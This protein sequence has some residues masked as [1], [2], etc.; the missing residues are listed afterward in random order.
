MSDRM[1]QNP[2]QYDILIVDDTPDSL[3]F[4]SRILE[5]SGFR[6]RAATNGRHA[7]KSVEAR[8]PGLILL[9]VRMPEMDGYEVCRRLKASKHSRNVP[10]IFISA[11][12]ETAEKLRGFKAGAVDFITKP[13]EEQEVL[14]RVQ[15]HLRLRE[16][17][18][19]LE[20]K[21]NQRTADLTLANRQL[22]KHRDHLEDLVKART[23]ELEVANKELA[24]AKEQAEAANAHK[25]DFL[26]RMSHDIRTP[27]NAVTGLTN[28]VLKSNLNAEQRDCLNKVK[29]AA[30]NLMQL[31]NDILD[32]TKVE[33]GRLELTHAPF[34]LDQVMDR[35]ADLFSD[36]VSKKDLKLRFSVAP[37]VPRLL[38]G[39]AARLSQVLS[40]LIGNAIKFTETGEIV[41]R[42]EPDNADLEENAR[43]T[44]KFSVSDT[45]AGIAADVLPTLFDPFTQ[46]DDS[47]T[48]RHEGTGLGLAICRQLAELLGGRIWAESTP[49]NGST[50]SFTAMLETRMEQPENA[51]P[52]RPQESAAVPIPHLAGRR[53]LVVEDIELNR[54]VAVMLLEE[55]GLN[56]EIAENGKVAVNKVTSS[57]PEYYDAVLMDIQMPVMDGYE[58]TRY[59]REWEAS[60]CAVRKARRGIAARNQHPVSGIRKP[61]SRIPIIAL[62]AHALKGEEEKCLAADMDDYLPKPIDEKNLH[63]VLLKWLS[64][65]MNETDT[66]RQ[67]LTGN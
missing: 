48:R 4:L 13:Y 36:Q 30:G 22:K 49:G 35:Q 57:G 1:I 62:T 45:G 33:A 2:D 47:L 16:L 66:K 58:A 26:A 8:L 5:V 60:E 12:G 67:G 18:E 40:N 37:K 7:L 44:L 9:D 56:V 14:A 46:A 51:A 50:F 31:I 24:A 63:R 34:D 19:H 20:H 6:V 41:V 21:V 61:G 59:I 42:V 17:T 53:V 23:G 27:L 55:I 39:D 28:L 54:D 43:V 38:A 65:R 32:F 29:L 11:L 52:R 10:V 15:T 25:S 3:G 64:P